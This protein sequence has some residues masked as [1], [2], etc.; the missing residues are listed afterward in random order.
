MNNIKKRRRELGLKNTDVVMVV[1][2]RDP[3]F[4]APALSKLENDA[5]LPTVPVA[6]ELCKVLECGILDLYEAKD[7]DIAGVGQ[8]VIV[9]TKK[10][11]PER[12]TSYHL[13]AELPVEY[14]DQLTDEVLK[15]CGYATR[16]D[17]LESC[18]KR[19]LKRYENIIKKEAAR[20]GAPNQTA[21][22]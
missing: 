21:K 12:K 6:E 3:R 8:R 22:G 13:C 2:K 19:L 15:K 11:P 10:A 17:W 9:R 1:R 18:A 20:M 14:G 7:I 4:D 5:F 16:R